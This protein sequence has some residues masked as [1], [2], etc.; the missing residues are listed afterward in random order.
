MVSDADLVSRLREFL[1]TSDLNTTTNAT[2][3]RQ[4]EADFGIDLSDRKAFLREQINLYLEQAQAQN[5]VKEEEERPVEESVR[6]GEQEDEKESAAAA[7]NEVEEG[8]E[9]S[10][11]TEE[12][13]AELKKTSNGRKAAKK[14]SK[15]QNKEVSRR[16]G[17]FTKLCGL[18]SQLQKFTGVPQMARTQVVK[19]L[20]NYIRENNLQDPSNK[21]NINCDDT[22]RELFEVDA[23]DMFQMNKALSKHIFQL[24]SDGASVSVNSTES[25]P[26]EKKRKKESDEDSDEPKG[27]EKRQKGGILAPLRLSDALAEFL[28]TGE[29]EL[30]RSNVIKRIWDYIKQNNLQDPS[31]RRRIICDEKLKELFNVDTFN[32]FSV[33]KLLTSHFIKT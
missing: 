17:G 27:G 13:E 29:S 11:E 5:A 3:R 22:L 6:G 15:K 20:W 30:P 31:D 26:K 9:E 18:S 28:G 1:S 14:R 12:E 33:S 4:L 7:E 8:E 19:Q 24:D 23:I 10:E 16:G 25:T 21:R 32:G 2:V